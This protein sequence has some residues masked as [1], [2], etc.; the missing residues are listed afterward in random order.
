MLYKGIFMDMFITSLSGSL[1]PGL[2][3]WSQTGA[4]FHNTTLLHMV[5]R[6]SL[7]DD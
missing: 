1:S 6:P 2:K 3:K 5:A 7:D 4:V